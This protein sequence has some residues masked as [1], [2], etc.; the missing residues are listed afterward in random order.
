[1]VVRQL[2]VH[3]QTDNLGGQPLSSRQRTWTVTGLGIG[4]LKMHRQRIVNVGGDAVLGQVC[5]QRITFRRAYDEQVKDTVLRRQSNQTLKLSSVQ[6]GQAAASGVPRV[7]AGK[8]G[9][10]HRRLDFV[11]SR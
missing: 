6:F 2:E 10:E 11:Q 1:L 3:R 9:R 5:P 4:R 8:L 7:Q